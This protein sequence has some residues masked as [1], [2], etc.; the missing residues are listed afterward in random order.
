LCG[1]LCAA[2]V[3]LC[4]FLTVRYNHRGDWSALFYE[5]ARAPA[6]PEL[7]WERHYRWPD[8]DGYDGQAY[9]LVAHDP[10]LRGGL[11]RYVD[12]PRLRY[13]RILVPLAAHVLA[14]G[15]PEWI[16]V[17]YRGVV[18]LSVFL[19]AWWV[20]LY[21]V[22]AGRSAA[23]GL[24]FALLPAVVV[25]A[26]RLTVDVALVALTAGFAVYDRA[27]H[28][29]KLYLVL[30]LAALS[31]ETGIL[32]AVAACAAAAIR[33]DRGGVL[34]A[35]AALAPAVAWFG[36]VHSRTAPY[37]YPGSMVPLSG[38]VRAL[39]DPTPA[40]LVRPGQVG[41]W[42][43]ITVLQ[44]PLFDRM[45]LAGAV[46]SFGL[47]FASLRRRPLGAID[48]A[49][50]LFAAVGVLVQRPDNWIHVYDFGRVYS[51]LLLLLGLRGLETR[52][53]WVAVPLLLMWPRIW[54]EVAMQVVGVL[55][56][57]LRT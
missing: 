6:A 40:P 41:E 3:L 48:I 24:A 53:G 1:A 8:S 38:V 28:P 7:A 37:D 21:A 56:A 34:L 33:R 22:R 42:W 44:T 20:A 47:A 23:W 16:D 9:H 18:V 11:A 13:R 27:S 17:A 31:R 55:R 46:V 14:L 43:R 50:A 10:F 12:A 51:P 54:V 25:S 52:S 29:W 4:Q 36:Y 32:L 35:L 2:A 45:A 30:A 57:L 15:R 19:G 26:D 5:G 49:A 39:I